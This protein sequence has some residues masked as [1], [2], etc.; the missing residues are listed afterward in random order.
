[1]KKQEIK[2]CEYKGG[3]CEDNVSNL[4]VFLLEMAR[5]P[6]LLSVPQ[7]VNFSIN[8]F[9]SFTARPPLL[10]RSRFTGIGEGQR[11]V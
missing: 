2:W 6:C 9:D 3:F 1:M 7:Q 8:S 4:A 10:G 5:P 11:I